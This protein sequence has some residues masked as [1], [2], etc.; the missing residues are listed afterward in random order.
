[1]KRILLWEK[2]HTYTKIDINV[3]KIP[4]RIFL[5][6][7]ENCITSNLSNSHFKTNP[8]TKTIQI[9]ARPMWETMHNIQPY[10]AENSIDR[11]RVSKYKNAK[12]NNF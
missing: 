7:E 6:N 3:T 8:N 10:L 1:M 11:Q 9:E 12:R 4:P 5:K 2:F